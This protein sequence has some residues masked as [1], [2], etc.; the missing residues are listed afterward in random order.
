[1]LMDDV[2]ESI[3][4]VERGRQ[5]YASHEEYDT[6]KQK[7][8]LIRE[9]FIEYG[10]GEDKEAAQAWAQAWPFKCGSQPKAAFARIF[11][12]SPSINNALL[13]RRASFKIPCE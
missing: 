6:L 5:G 2:L 10:A 4:G 8:A 1:M 3:G 11:K 12:C 7:L 9:Q 13:Q